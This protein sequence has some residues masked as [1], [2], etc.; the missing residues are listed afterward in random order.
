MV[1]LAIGYFCA[2]RKWLLSILLLYF[3]RVI[4]AQADIAARW[5]GSDSVL[6]TIAQ[7]T[8][9]FPPN[10]ERHFLLPA[11]ERLPVQVKTRFGVFRSSNYLTVKAGKG[12][13][14]IELQGLNVLVKYT[15]TLHQN[16]TAEAIALNMMLV[17]GGSFLMGT[18][19]GPPKERPAHRVRLKNFYLSKYEV[20]N[21]EWR[22]IMGHD[23]AYFRSCAQ[24][25]VENITWDNAQRFINRLNELSG[26]RYRLPT[27]AEWEYAA[28]GGNETAGNQYSGSNILDDVAWFT[29]NSEKKTHPVGTKMPNELGIYDMSG[30]VW[31]WCSD[32]YGEN[33]YSTPSLENP[34]GPASGEV[35]VLRGGSWFDF[36]I[37]CRDTNRFIPAAGYRLYIIGFR[38]AMDGE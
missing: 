24:C 22:N 14:D 32:W 16:T 3:V 7:S 25:P 11:N 29:T 2:V 6:I 5:H 34:K 13:A 33:Y 21:E 37:E 1:P 10:S 31:E 35:H 8:I 28:R 17:A 20:T 27:E 12:E 36:D 15:P 23:T 38:L 26:K 30:N 9:S 18:N 19:E 4:S